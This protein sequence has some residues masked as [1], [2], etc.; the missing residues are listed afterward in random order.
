MT[1][2]RIENVVNPAL[3]ADMI[4]EGFI[5]ERLHPTLPLK[6]YN[7][8]ERAQYEHVWTNETR[9][10]RGLIV[11]LDGT[12]LAR[13][14]K[15]FFNYGEYEQGKIQAPPLNL[16]APVQVTDKMDGSL[17][18]LYRTPGGGAIATRGSFIS[19]QAVHASQ[20]YQ[21][22]YEGHWAPRAGFTYLFEI[23]YPENRIVL[24]YAGLDDLVLLGAV[25]IETGMPVGPD[26]LDEW[27]GARTQVFDY[28]TLTHALA[29]EPR[30]NA[31]GL[32]VRFRG[33]STMVKI[34]QDDYVALHRLVT[35]LNERVVWEHLSNS[36]SVLSL[37]ESIPD[38]FHAWVDEKAAALQRK[39]DQI[40]SESQII[41]EF[42]L[43]DLGEGFERRT[44]AERAAHYSAERPFLF[45]LLDGK[46][47]SS[48]IWK[49]LKPRGDT[50]MLG[51]TEDVA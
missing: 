7:Y 32:V 17:G 51:I 28:P 50:Y 37:V 3:L 9:S 47:P 25:E 39:H 15:K 8:S 23:I 14:W 16:S 46:N 26:L 44:F 6:I 10:C 40:A 4:A 38:E 48:G 1:P 36:G 49:T 33:T 29:A 41:Y 45:N 18:V 2:T 5:R 19:E 35:G 43:R 31:E 34:K 21:E 42:I 22:R 20:I 24:D 12:V 27:P 30:T 11:G 13:P